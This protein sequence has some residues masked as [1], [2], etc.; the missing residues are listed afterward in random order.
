MP[1]LDQAVARTTRTTASR[2][3]SRTTQGFTTRRSG[4]RPRIA[5]TRTTSTRTRGRQIRGVTTEALGS[6]QTAGI[7]GANTLV[8]R[9][10][11]L[12]SDN[13]Q[14]IA[15]LVVGGFVGYYWGSF[16]P[17]GRYRNYYGYP[18]YGYGYG[19]G[20]L[21][22][23]YGYD[24]G[25]YGSAV[26]YSG[27]A[28]SGFSIG[29]GYGRYGSTYGF[30]ACDL[31]CSGY[32][33]GGYAGLPAPID[34]TV[35]NTIFANG[36]AE[37]D[38]HAPF[39]GIDRD[40]H[41]ASN[42]TQMAAAPIELFEWASPAARPFVESGQNN[43]ADGNYLA[44][45]K[46]FVEAILV[47]PQDAA[48][49]IGYGLAYLA[50]GQHDIAFDSITTALRTEPDLIYSGFDLSTF[51]GTPEALAAHTAA[52][53]ALLAN[54]SDDRAGWFLLGYLTWLGGDPDAAARAFHLAIGEGGDA[55]LAELM[56]DE[57]RAAGASAERARA[58]TRDRGFLD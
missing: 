20:G 31:Q 38:S 11:S 16:G 34:N 33:Y 9:T 5:A 1:G 15:A 2:P 30:G 45:R 56:R 58:P 46:D 51:Y 23:N 25:Y 7:S 42:P 50:Q 37:D 32:P 24:S 43:F 36:V 44:A 27:Y 35:N 53:E 12:W 49:R 10:R 55:V 4:R 52:L 17:Y 18:N 39:A 40:T 21:Y 6:T 29:L 13:G 28:G 8:D 26:G 54:Q 19:Y 57:A 47:D 3:S 48:S 41:P 22:G 14:V